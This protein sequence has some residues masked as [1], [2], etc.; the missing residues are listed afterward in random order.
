MLKLVP[1][2]QCGNVIPV[3]AAPT[4]KKKSWESE[5]DYQD[6]IARQS[7]ENIDNIKQEQLKAQQL[8]IK[9]EKNI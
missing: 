5:E 8:N 6:R 4:L 3:R 2:Y 7:K 1:K 9:I